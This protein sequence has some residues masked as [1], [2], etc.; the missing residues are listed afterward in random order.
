MSNIRCTVQSCAFNCASGCSLGDIH[1]GGNEAVESCETSCESF[2]VA[3]AVMSVAKRP[4]EHS[5]VGCDARNCVHNC[6]GE[7]DAGSI[8]ISGKHS[9]NVRDTQCDSFRER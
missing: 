8:D 1:V 2:T 3:N 6:G 7:C 9:K 4:E 5:S